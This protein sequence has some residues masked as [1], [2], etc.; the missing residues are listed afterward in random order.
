MTR[1]L[2][3]D[4]DEGIREAVREALDLEGYEV[5]MAVSGEEAL[6]I[7][8]A[9]RLDA[10]LLDIML[11]GMDGVDVCARLRESASV[12]VLLLTAR[13]AVSDRV[14]GL[15][16]GA[17]DYLTKPFELDEL[18]ARIRAMLRRPA[19][20]QQGHALRFGDVVLDTVARHVRRGSRDIDLSS[21]EFDLLRALLLRP[22]IPI[23][24]SQ[25]LDTVWR[26]PATS[27]ALDVY[28]GYLRTKLEA[29]GEPRI[30]HTVRDVGYMLREADGQ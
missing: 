13:D 3:V 14:R 7:A 29:G 8:A 21:R 25:L 20:I 22:G 27:R 6:A 15:D 10:I 24:R 11:P 17:D 1:I 4:D 18:L 19:A 12:P 2:V 28:I 23:P 5:E 30:I 9:H 16:A 26:H